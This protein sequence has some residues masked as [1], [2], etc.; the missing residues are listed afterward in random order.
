MSGLR[1]NCGQW[2][3]CGRFDNELHPLPNLFRGLDDLILGDGNNVPEMIGQNSQCALT[4]CCA[5]AI[6][7][8][9]RDLVCYQ[10]PRAQRTVSIIGYRWLGAKQLDSRPHTRG[11]N[12][13]TAEESSA[14]DRGNDYVEIGYIFQ[15]FQ[16]RG[17]LPGDNEWIVKRVHQVRAGLFLELACKFGKVRDTR[18]IRDLAPVTHDSALLGLGS[19]LWHCDKSG[20]ALHSRCQRDR[21]RVVSR[22]HCDDPPLRLGWR[23]RHDRVACAPELECSYLLK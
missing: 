2:D 5:Q 20:D 1:K 11:G 12:T 15:Q 8:C 10:T 21:S 23:Q 16:R 13:G 17:S 3:G 14:A 18:A 9:W 22:R 19:C 4:Q 7:N 6:G